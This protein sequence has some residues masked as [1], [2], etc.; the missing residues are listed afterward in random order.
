NLQLGKWLM[1]IPVQ[2]DRVTRAEPYMAHY[3]FD[4]SEEQNRRQ[5]TAP[6]QEILLRARTAPAFFGVLCCVAVFAIGFWVYNAWAGL[7]AAGLLLSNSLFLMLSSQAMT[8]A[9]YNF[10]LLSCCLA[11]IAFAKARTPKQA[12]LITVLS[13]ILAALACSV[14]ITGILLG[15]AIFF[16]VV[17]RRYYAGGIQR[18]EVLR[19][20]AVFCLFAVGTVYALNPVFWPSWRELKMGALLQEARSFSGEIAASK[21]IPHQHEEV[22][23]LGVRYPQLRNVGNVLEFPALFIRWSRSMQRQIDHANW[24]GNRVLSIH[25]ELFSLGPPLQPVES[26][27]LTVEIPG[28]IL[29]TFT[30]LG[31]FFLCGGRRHALFES[32]ED[33]QYVPLIYLLVNYSLVVLF[34]K[35]NWNRYYLPTIIAVDLVAAVGIYGALKYGFAYLAGKMTPELIE[36]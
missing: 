28:L 13:G 24:R 16:L 17:L 9:F 5:G 22:T 27:G 19:L 3:D 15:G 34:L 4:A 36:S 23:S 7:I 20:L 12:L 31:I 32:E 21:R 26:D 6:R 29:A 30:G 25:R 1:G 35:L 2:A 10:F 14:K 8:D 33:A 18:S 11:A